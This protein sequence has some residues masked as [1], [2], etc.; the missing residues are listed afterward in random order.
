MVYLAYTGAQNQFLTEEPDFTHFRTVYVRN[1]PCILKTLNIPFDNPNPGNILICTVPQIGSYLNKVTLKF[2]LPRLA[3]DTSVWKYNNP[4]VGGQMFAYSTTNTLLY[5]VTITSSNTRT[6]STS[7]YNSGGATVTVTSGN[8]F[9]FTNGSQVSYI[10]FTNIETAHFWGFL[11]NYQTLFGGYVKFNLSGNPTTFTS[12]VTFQE[13]GWLPVTS[14]DRYIDDTIYKLINN[15]SLY[16]G[17]N[18]IQRI[19]GTLLKVYDEID[20]SYKNKPV[21]KLL[22]G[23]TNIVDFNRI[24]YMNVPFIKIPMYSIPRH[25]VRI[26]LELNQF[27]SISNIASSLVLEALNFADVNK[28]PTEHL[29]QIPQFSRFDKEK[30]HTRGPVKRIISIGDPNFTF[31]LNGETFVDSDSSNVSSFENTL[32][33]SSTSNVILV[34]NTINMSRIRD[35]TFRSSNTVVYFESINFLKISNEISGLLFDYTDTP[36]NEILRGSLKI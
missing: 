10:V 16:I 3:T 23:N 27:D 14:N 24:Y 8:K 5:I 6:D 31:T 19:D 30:I 18:L 15:I 34:N 13:C 4:L 2:V 20:T 29:I 11:Y 36:M 9:S 33:I 7:W 17:N 12:Q 32:N 26:I 1:E 35:Q 28:L 22:E 25:D 21:L